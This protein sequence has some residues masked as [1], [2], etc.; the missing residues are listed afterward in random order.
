VDKRSSS[1]PNANPTLIASSPLQFVAGF[2]LNWWNSRNRIVPVESKGWLAW[3][4]WFFDK[5]VT[6][7]VL[8][9]LLTTVSEASVYILVR[10]LRAGIPDLNTHY[11]HDVVDDSA[12]YTSMADDG[13]RV[14]DESDEFLGDI[15]SLGE[16]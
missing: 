12:I 7:I 14:T 4:M 6:S 5:G 2:A 1:S 16:L 10:S 13:S 8:D 3:V 11:V 15:G 9:Y